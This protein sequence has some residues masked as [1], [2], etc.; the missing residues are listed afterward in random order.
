[1]GSRC[2]HCGRLIACFAEN[3]RPGTD[4]EAHIHTGLCL[5]C[6]IGPGVAHAATRLGLVKR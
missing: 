1:M 3:Y 5:L 4:G 6:T 2:R